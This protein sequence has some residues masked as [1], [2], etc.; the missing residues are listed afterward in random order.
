MDSIFYPYKVFIASSA[1]VIDE[2]LTKQHP[3][4]IFVI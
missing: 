3:L 4:D 2:N 1:F